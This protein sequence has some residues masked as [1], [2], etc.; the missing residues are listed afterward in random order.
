MKGEEV[1]AEYYKGFGTRSI[2]RFEDSYGE[3]CGSK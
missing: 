3:V 2:Y 1:R